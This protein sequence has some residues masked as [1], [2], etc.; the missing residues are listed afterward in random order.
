[1]C[2]AY[3][4]KIISSLMK[5]VVNLQQAQVCTGIMQFLTCNYTRNIEIHGY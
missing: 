5:G 1:M 4:Y 2:A 3:T